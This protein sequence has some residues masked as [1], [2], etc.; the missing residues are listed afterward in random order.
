MWNVHR[1]TPNILITGTPGVGK[2]LMARTLAEKTELTWLDVNKLAAESGFL[3][4]YDEV[5]QCSVL[6]EDKLLDSME[7]LM[8]QGGKIVDYHSAEM[9]PE[10]WFDVIFVL[11][12]NNTVLYDRLKER[13]YSGRKLEDNIDCEIFETILEEARASYR[14]EIVHELPNDD[15]DQL[16]DNVNRICQWLEQ[17]KIDNRQT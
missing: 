5:H 4:E 7:D 14:E 9:F 6:N 16:A 8:I 12:T 11:R 1:S 3:E 2:S 17:W 15:L 13:G 10:R